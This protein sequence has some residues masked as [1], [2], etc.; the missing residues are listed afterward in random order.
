M[1]DKR[2]LWISLLSIIAIGLVMLTATVAAGWAPKLGLD[3]AGGLSVVYETHNPVTATELDTIT[4][5]LNERVG[6]SSGATV[7]SQGTATCPDKVHKCSLIEAA[8]PGQKNTQQI[9]D[10]LGQTAQLF[11]R[12]A[13]CYAPDQTVAKGEKAATGPL[14]TCSTASMLTASN[15]DVNQSTGQAGANPEPDSQFTPYPS[16]SPL[17]D[18]KSAT[19]L[20]PGPPGQGSVRYVLGPSPVTGAEIK[21]ANASL[22]S[23]GQWTV[24]I[25]FNQAGATAWDTLAQEQ[26]HAIIGIDLD[27]QVISAPLTQP[28]QPSFTSFAGQVQISGSFTQDQAQTLATELNYGA[29]PVKLDQ[30]TIQT[31]SPSLGK[32][33]LQAGLISGLIGLALVMIYTIFYYRLLGLVVV[34]GLAL[35][36]ALLWS[37]IAI[38]GQTQN[39]TID[40]AGVIGIIVSIGITVDSYIV[41]FERLKDE[42]RSG[43]TVRTSV[44]RGFKSAFRTVL[45]ADFVSLLGAV[46]LYFFSIGDVRGFALF[47]GISTALDIIVTYFFTRPFVILLGRSRS[48]TEAK[49]MGVAS[50]L[51][52]SAGGDR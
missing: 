49:T 44:D 5:I 31:V 12:P 8:V 26:F 30:Q 22:S 7:S 40:L 48:A 37:I 3:L 16:T 47:L 27:G 6:G 39:T 19:V 20:L 52:M 23:T 24:N 42:A 14:P 50:G 34:S 29:L 45:A 41:Y 28:T 10:R 9:L 17:N 1:K 35:T 33:S 13:L 51:G 36:G 15:L 25:N 46:V 21:S 2:S 11:F 38:L 4:T 18:T 43:R 32:S